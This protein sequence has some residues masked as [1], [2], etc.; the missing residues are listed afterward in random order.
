MT[1]EQLMKELKCLNRF[2]ELQV[3]IIG[4]K[5]FIRIKNQPEYTIIVDQD[6]KPELIIK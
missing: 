5:G 4:N 3:G 1:I 2:A 6:V